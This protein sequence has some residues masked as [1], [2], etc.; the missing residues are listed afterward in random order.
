MNKACERCNKLAVT[1][2]VVTKDG[3]R[4]AAQLCQECVT[5]VIRPKTNWKVVS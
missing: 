5:I 4:I 3:P 2:T 1:R